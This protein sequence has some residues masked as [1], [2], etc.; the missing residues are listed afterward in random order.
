VAPD[1]KGILPG[2]EAGKMLE[3]AV[4]EAPGIPPR[5]WK[6]RSF[7]FRPFLD[8]PADGTEDR[9]VVRVHVFE[10]DFDPEPF[11]DRG[12]KLDEADR[13]DDAPLHEIEVVGDVFFRN[14][15]FLERLVKMGNDELPHLVRIDD[16]QFPASSIF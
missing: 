12:E 6:H 9:E 16:V 5:S 15:V 14:V 7:L 13:I 11:L 10:I 8:V 3:E 2:Q 1:A 4:P